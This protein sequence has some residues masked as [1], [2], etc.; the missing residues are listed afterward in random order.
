MNMILK[1]FMTKIDPISAM[2]FEEKMKKVE[3]AAKVAK[4]IPHPAVQK[5]AVGVQTGVKVAK[6]V[7]KVAKKNAAA[8]KRESKTLKPKKDSLDLFW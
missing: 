2:P 1:T 5:T 6:T 7:K 4:H 8:L 3:F